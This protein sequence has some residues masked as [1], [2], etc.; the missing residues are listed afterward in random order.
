MPFYISLCT[1]NVATNRIRSLKYGSVS[2]Y[3]SRF[4]LKYFQNNRMCL[5]QTAIEIS[6][7]CSECWNLAEI[8]LRTLIK[9]IENKI[10]K[11]I[12]GLKQK[13]YK[14]TKICN[15]TI[16][17]QQ[18]TKNIYTSQP[19]YILFNHTDYFHLPIRIPNW[20]IADFLHNTAF[21]TH[22]NQ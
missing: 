8:T 10:T 4:I 15:N 2:E 21:Q 11:K 17:K 12:L 5:Q 3:S 14:N 19:P 20:A 9:N 1:E 13:R 6:S 18:N 7:H 22:F 16:W